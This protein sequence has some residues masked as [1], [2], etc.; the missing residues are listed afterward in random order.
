MSTARGPFASTLAEDAGERL[1]RRVR[2]GGL[3]TAVGI[4]QG[5]T[6]ALLLL[7]VVLRPGATES[8][9]RIA[10]LVYDPAAAAALP[11]P[12]GSPRGSTP[13]RRE[14]PKPVIDESAR[15]EALLPAPDLKA[16]QTEPEQH[17]PEAGAD[18]G[19]ERGDAS[20]ME[21]GSE[22]GMIGGVREGTADGVPNGTGNGPV[23]DYDAPPRIVRQTQPRYPTQAFVQRVEGTVVLEIVIDP[24]GHVSRARVIQSIPLLDAAARDAVNEWL[25]QPAL[26][27]GRPVSSIAHAPVR[28][29]IY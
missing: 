18:N 25:F 28:F 26:K 6:V 8:P 17:R 27:R 12:R 22:D 24:T 16:Q 3:M 29:H 15:T 21:G 13:V 19:S 23:S 20:G 7:A 2:M 9:D 11:L 1:S 4:A 5:S 14:A 10:S